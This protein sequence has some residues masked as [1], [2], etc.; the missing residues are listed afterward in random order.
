MS[1]GDHVTDLPPTFAPLALTPSSVA[2]MGD[3]ARGIY[4]VQF[5]PEVQHTPQGK[6][7]LHNFVLDICGCRPDWTPA[8]F[9]TES[10]ANLQ[11]QVGDGRVICGL[12]GGVDSAVVAAL[13]HRAIG[14]RLTCIFVDHGLLRQ[15]EAPQ[16]VE[17]FQRHM[18]MRLIAVDAAD[19]FIS[20][21]AGT[22]D[23]EEKRKRIGARFI[24][25]FEAAEAE[26]ATCRRGRSRRLPGPGHP[27]PGCDRVGQPARA[28]HG[29][30]HQDASQRRRS[31]RGHELPA[32]RAAAQPVQG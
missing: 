29:P 26:A 14:D 10:V 5:H 28:S 8:N 24:R 3:V 32:H 22:V 20:D 25:T 2:A 12:S 6:E 31:A 1:H 21:L 18:G 7:L 4:G 16:V 11:A 27:L 30:H 19:E 9:I 17:T 13:L 15:G 23:P